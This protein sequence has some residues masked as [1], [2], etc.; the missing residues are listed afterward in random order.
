MTNSFVESGIE[1][2][3]EKA[4][5]SEKFDQQ[6]Q[7]VSSD[8]IL[9]GMKFVDFLVEEE[10]ELLLIEI[11]N[12]SVSPTSPAG[13]FHIDARR[14]EIA[15]D[16]ANKN[17]INKELVPKARDSFT[18]LHLMEKDT[19]P[20]KYIVYIGLEK[21]PVDLKLIPAFIDRLR[22]RLAQEALEP[23]KRKYATECQVIISL[24]KWNKAF[25]NY[26]AIPANR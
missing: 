20:I 24:E 16:L 2:D 18:F 9:E 11:K 13:Q 1:F 10:P 8:P 17:L 21:V 5:S 14:K 23:W 22:K 12:P 3:F 7:S 15:K 25:P 6:Q 19:K 26:P 4:Q